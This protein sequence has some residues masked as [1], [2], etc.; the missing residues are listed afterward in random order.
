MLHNVQVKQNQEED[1][2]DVQKA[3]MADAININ[4]K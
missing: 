4:K 1:V 2:K 3:Q